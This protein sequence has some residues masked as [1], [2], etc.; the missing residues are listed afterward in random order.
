[1]TYDP[2]DC[3]LTALKHT[4]TEIAVDSLLKLLLTLY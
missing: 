1:M 3:F 4:S 2:E